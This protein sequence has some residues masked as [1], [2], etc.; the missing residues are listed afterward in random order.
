MSLTKL[1]SLPFRYKIWN[2]HHIKLIASD[3]IKPNQ[4]IHDH[5][6]HLNAAINWLC[7]A[8][9]IRSDMPDSGG[10]SAGWSFEDNWLPSYPETS[11]YIVETFVAAAKLLDQP[12]LLDRANKILDW[13]LS[14]QNQ[15]GSFPG[16]FGEASS[17]P[18]IFNT[19]QIMHGMNCGY[20]E[21]KRN[22]CLESAIKAGKWL[23]TQQDKDGC[24]R[25]ST[26]NGIIHTY[27]TRAAWALLQ[28]G[29]LA[30]DQSLINAATQNIDWALSQQL[31]NGWFENNAFTTDAEPFTHTIAYAIR[32]ILECGLLL[33]NKHYIQA[34]EKAAKALAN[35]QRTDGSIAGTYDKVWQ[36]KA[37]YVCLTGLAQT[38][39]IWSQLDQANNNTAFQAHIDSA[40]NY[41]KQKQQIT[42]NASINDGAIAGSFPIWGRYS[43]F[44]YPNWAAKFFA[45]ALIA[46]ATRKQTS[47]QKN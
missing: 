28:T 30:N 25:R 11:G 14:I 45:D 33:N 29:L 16:H 46:D 8:Q 35:A 37:Y 22:E 36:S 42:N 19:G 1:I 10:V 3:L 21:L 40:L 2:P 27:N 26:H 39:I 32:G 34:A 24:W 15:D 12:K 17:K 6:I 7:K 43:M 23:I 31:D 44:E 47:I 5:K 4:V 20:Q 18:V 13:E 38:S 41:L 9:D